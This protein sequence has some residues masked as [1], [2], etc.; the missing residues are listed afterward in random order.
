MQ[1]LCNINL[2]GKA[3]KNIKKFRLL[4]TIKPYSYTIMSNFIFQ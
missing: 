3:S 4:A 1:H 2:I